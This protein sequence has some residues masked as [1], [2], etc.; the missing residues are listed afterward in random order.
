MG[1]RIEEKRKKLNEFA[2]PGIHKVR[3]NGCAKQSLSSTTIK[4]SNK[5]Q[6]LRRKHNDLCLNIDEKQTFSTKFCTEFEKKTEKNTKN[7]RLI[8]TK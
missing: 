2:M 6:W 5:I 3:Q 7:S 4:K 8:R 1:T